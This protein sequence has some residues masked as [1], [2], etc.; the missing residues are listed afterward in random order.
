MS[1]MKGRNRKEDVQKLYH[2]AIATKTN[3][4]EPA[5]AEL[6]SKTKAKKM[7]RRTRKNKCS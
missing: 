6:K 7:R 5:R 3:I 4:K 1:R 2:P